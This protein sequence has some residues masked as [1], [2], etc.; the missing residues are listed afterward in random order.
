MYMCMYLH[1]H[2]CYV[3]MCIYFQHTMF[4]QQWE[5]PAT[6][7]NVLQPMNGSYDGTKFHDV[8]LVAVPGLVITTTILISD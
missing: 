7:L 5:M 3:F 6:E 2:V 1:M 8:D 4:P